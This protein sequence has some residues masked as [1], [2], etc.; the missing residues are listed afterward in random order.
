MGLRAWFS[1]EGID[2][3]IQPVPAGL[4]DGRFQPNPSKLGSCHSEDEQPGKLLN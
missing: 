4:A 3:R 1:V 2:R